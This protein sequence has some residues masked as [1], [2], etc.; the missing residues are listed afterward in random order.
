MW[1]IGMPNLGHTMEF[2]KVA[3]WLKK[4]GDNVAAGEAIA[5]IE[6]DK[7]TVD[8]ESPAAG[9][10]LA[11]FAEVA[12][13]IA[14]G[15][16][17]AVVGE[18]SEAEAAARAADTPVTAA[19]PIE[20]PV[21]VASP[22]KL[23]APAGRSP[24]SPAARR[25][26]EELGLDPVRISG[27]GEGG[28]VTRADVE[29]AAANRPIPLILLHGFGADPDLFLPMRAVLDFGRA[30]EAP[31]LPGHDGGVELPSIPDIAALAKTLGRTAPFDG[32]KRFFLC[33]H[34]LGAA[35]A[36]EIAKSAPERV[37]GLVL[38]APP[39]L[40]AP[41][42]TRFVAD[43]LAGA[44]AA[45]ADAALAKLVARPDRISVA[46]RQQ[47]I[48]RLGD[49]DRVARLRRVAE[50]CLTASIAMGPAIAAL[51]CPVSILWGREDR[52][53]APPAFDAIPSVADFA[54]VAAA[55]HLLP[56]ERPAALARHLAA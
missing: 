2:G 38:V 52:V 10:L 15:A 53:L 43:F 8:V 21:H 48:R 7:V 22:R 36:I 4:P 29:S 39:G 30:V 20:T 55:G 1:K 42:D 18:P 13:S 56:A 5:V 25:R 6:T 11:V 14:V 26:A 51:Q 9:V 3:S 33:G 28:L 40:G 50:A 35:L 54:L 27:T 34:S 31:A 49:P 12:N 41:I 32:A 47:T 17:I 46:F 44:E 45:R 24:I 19:T 16:T 23:A 37:A